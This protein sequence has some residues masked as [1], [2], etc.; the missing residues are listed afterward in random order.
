MNRTLSK[1]SAIYT[2]QGC[3]HNVAF[4]PTGSPQQNG[5]GA[6]LPGRGARRRKLFRCALRAC[7]PGLRRSAGSA[8]L[9]GSPS[10][11]DRLPAPRFRC[12]RG[13]AQRALQS[14][15]VV[16][17]EVD[18]SS[19]RGLQSMSGAFCTSPRTSFCLTSVPRHRSQ[20]A[21]CADPDH[22]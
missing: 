7:R 4:R 14:T 11:T 6:R 9:R 5:T 22:R 2:R 18:M 20:E 12:S 16:Q 8:I 15:A 3:V 17:L 13:P 21:A 19:T 1:K 10:S